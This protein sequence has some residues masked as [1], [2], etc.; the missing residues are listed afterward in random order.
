MEV[1][2]AA[3]E[4]SATAHV[5]HF[6]DLDDDHY[7]YRD[8]QAQ[9]V[10]TGYSGDSHGTYAQ[11]PM[12]VPESY[13][14]SEMRSFDPYTNA[15]V[16]SGAA[17][18]GAA[19]VNRSKSVTAPYNAFAGPQGG[20]PYGPAPSQTMYDAQPLTP[21]QSLRYRQRNPSAGNELDLLEAAGM[22]GGAAALAGAAGLAHSSSQP[23]S[24][25]TT[26]PS[27]P[28]ADLARNK[29]LGAQTLGSSSGSGENEHFAGANYQQPFQTQPQQ[30]QYLST[31]SR[32]ISAVDPYDGI[33]ASSPVAMPNPHSPSAQPHPSD[34]RPM[35]G[36]YSSPDESEHDDGNGG[37]NDGR[38]SRDSL[39]GGEDYEYGNDR[40]VL[41]VSNPFFPSSFNSLTTSSRLPMSKPGYAYWTSV[42][43]KRLCISPLFHFVYPALFPLVVD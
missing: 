38:D 33:E 14:M 5:P 41:K 18:V 19:G 25:T 34:P 23:A 17:G 11:Q 26:S 31:S 13:N 24:S 1:A 15:G 36:N 35:S 43:S 21:G 2:E 30:Y 37:Y 9:S 32:P 39:R 22:G 12:A 42:S 4:A 8:P 29:S 10:Y 40:R 6:D 7:G 28:P 27:P 16:G 20:D 3:A